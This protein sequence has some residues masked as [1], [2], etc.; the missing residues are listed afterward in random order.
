MKEIQKSFGDPEV[1]SSENPR[2]VKVALIQRLVIAASRS[3]AAPDVPASA[4]VCLSGEFAKLRSLIKGQRSRSCHKDAEFNKH[5][6][7]SRLHNRNRPTNV[8]LAPRNRKALLQ[9]FRMHKFS[10][11]GDL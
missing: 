1:V 3:A 5:C 9:A 11:G 8:L 2:Q 4:Q 7:A 10:V 6:G